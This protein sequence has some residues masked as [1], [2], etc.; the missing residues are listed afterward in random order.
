MSEQILSQE[1]T[2][3]GLKKRKNR[4]LD[5][6]AVIMLV[7]FYLPMAIMDFI[8]FTQARIGSILQIFQVEIPGKQVVWGFGNITRLFTEGFADTG[9]LREGLRNSLLFFS[10]NFIGLPLNFIFAYF[11]YKKLA[12]HKVFRIIYYLPNI[13]PGIVFSMLVKYM[14]APDGSG[15]LAS[16]VYQFGGAS[17]PNIFGDSRYAIWGLLAYTVWSSFC[18]GF[19]LPLSS[20][21]RV[22][23]EVIESAQ[24]D[25]I[26]WIG[27]IKDII[28]PLIFP[29]LMMLIIQLLPMIFT[30]SGA[31]LFFTQGDYGTQTISYWIFDRVRT[32]ND[33]NYSTTVSFFFSLLT[34]PISLFAYWLMNKVPAVEY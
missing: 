34:L 9:V 15:V 19:L 2:R 7:V 3:K 18:A 25:G 29:V 23:Q 30:S 32:R 10:L 28:L 1:K 13:I 33:L 14:T 11:M 4:N 17:F 20:M 6:A 26:T 8:S 22:P 31:V 5:R 27:E 12:G 24:L 16:L 21:K